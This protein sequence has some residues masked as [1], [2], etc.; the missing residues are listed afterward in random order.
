MRIRQRFYSD[1]GYLPSVYGYGRVSHPSQL[2][3]ANGSDARD[4]A[5]SLVDQ[6]TRIKAY[7]ALR[8]QSVGDALYGIQW[9]QMFCEPRAQSAYT[10]PFP[11]RPAGKLLMERLCPG[12]HLVIDKLD[13]VFRDMEDFCLRRRYFAERGIR[14]HFVNFFGLAF[15]TG[16]PGGELL[17]QMQVLFSQF[18]SATT[19]D[20]TCRARSA[21]RAR[22]RSA[23]TIPPF[24]C[25]FEQLEGTEKKQQG[26]TG[27]LV[28][29]DWAVPV[30][31]KIVW[32]KDE[33]RLGFDTVA[34]VITKDKAMPDPKW[35]RVRF[36]YRFYHAWNSV[37]RPDINTFKLHEFVDA[38]WARI[39]RETP[40]KYTFP[41][42]K[43]QPAA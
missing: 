33:Q 39:K 11:K 41:N 38:H 14:L 3:D 27:K 4:P 28:M 29:L 20:R 13:R 30:M 10:K 18:E 17:L 1:P 22:G 7:Y 5:G 32:L 25:R 26:G 35:S 42:A 2:P 15:D 21:L 23:G 36:L 34:R 31:E 12:D 6:E 9:G 43:A 24:F 37:G 8:S 16:C 40:D 19:S